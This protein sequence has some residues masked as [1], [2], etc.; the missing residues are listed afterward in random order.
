MPVRVYLK[1]CIIPFGPFITIKNINAMRAILAGFLLLLFTSGLRSQNTVTV[2]DADIGPNDQVTWTSDNVYLLDGYVF[3]DSG[4]TLTIEK[5]TVIKGRASNNISTGDPA[6]ALIVV[7]TAKVYANGTATE[8]II[9][10]AEIDDINDPYDLDERDRGLWGGVII[11]GSAPVGNSSPIATIE[12][13]PS[14]E[15]RIKFGG[16]KS[17]DNSGSL[18]Y[19]SIRHGGA[20]LSPGDEINGLTLGGVGS[21]TVLEHIEVFANKDDGI[22]FFG[23]SPMLKWAA[24]AF[25]AD[26][27]FDWDLGY[28]GSG[29]FWFCIQALDDGDLAA[30]MDGAKPDGNAIYSNPTVFNATYFGTGIDNQQA[31][32]IALLFR[33]AT[34][35]KYYNSIFTDFGNKMIQVEDLPAGSGVDSRQRMEDGELILANNV[36]YGFGNYSTLSADLNT[37]Y[38]QYTS[39][40][41]DSSAQFLIDHFNNNNNVIA[42]PQIGGI[43]R[44]PDG[45]LDPRPSTNGPATQSLAAYPT[46]PFFTE[47]SYKGAFDPAAN[48]TWADG[49]TALSSYGYLKTYVGIEKKKPAAYAMSEI[50]PNPARGSVYFTLQSADNKSA[51]IEVLNGSG[52]VIMQ[53]SVKLNSGSKQQ[54]ELDLHAFPSGVY[55]V[56]VISD[57]F[58]VSRKVF[59]F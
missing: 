41:E 52:R 21:G 15:S 16:N 20:E 3:V 50:R 11:L 18:S 31:G 17:N 22:E 55:F 2:K 8:P 30:E 5:G 34:A 59:L 19:V 47:V 54:I 28:R 27:G 4:A 24:V 12:G 56:R 58:R 53:R 35:G 49:W 42:D 48:G 37:G 7:S 57:A 43:S 38:I 40:A 32:G 33:D 13:I 23:G 46:D 51:D 14:T 9:F 6:S 26:D 10:T 1:F 29:Q 39:G 25:C 45:G 36:F 44:L